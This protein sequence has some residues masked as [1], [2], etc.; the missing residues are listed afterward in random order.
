MEHI[1]ELE[2][3][4]FIGNILDALCIYL[5][6]EVDTYHA[7]GG[8]L[9]RCKHISMQTGKGKMIVEHR[10][11]ETYSVRGFPEERDFEDFRQ[12][13]EEVLRD[14]REGAY[15]NRFGDIHRKKYSNDRKD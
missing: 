2:G 9:E 10:E 8:G 4:N 13:A 1:L 11:G 7:Q 14:I 6:L 12:R 5:E 15:R 3:V